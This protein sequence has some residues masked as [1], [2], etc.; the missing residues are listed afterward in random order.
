MS[1]TGTITNSEEKYTYNDF[2]KEQKM[3]IIKTQ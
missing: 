2:L 3:L 1:N